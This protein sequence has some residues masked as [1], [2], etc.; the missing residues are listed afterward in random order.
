MRARLIPAALSGAL[1]A[2]GPLAGV[3]D[4]TVSGFF[5]QRLELDSNPDLESSDFSSGSANSIT[6]LGVVLSMRTPRTT[7]TFAPGINASLRTDQSVT[8]SN[9]N[10]RV[11][12]RVTRQGERL[13][14]SGGMSVVPRLTNDGASASD[15]SFSAAPGSPDFTDA[16]ALEVTA[17]ADARARYK[18]D[19]RNSV[20]TGA[21]AQARRFSKDSGQFTD[22][23]SYGVDL[24]WTRE[25]DPRTSLSLKTAFRAFSED[26]GGSDEQSLDFTAGG[27]RRLSPTLSA[28]GDIGVSF[29]DSG[30]STNAGLIG[31]ARLNYQ[32]KDTSLV[33]GFRQSVDQNEFGDLENRSSAFITPSYRATH[34]ASV[35]L[36][37][38]MS[39]TNPMFS[40]SGGSDEF[41]VSVG[42][43]LSYDLTPEWRID[44]GYRLR[45]RAESGRTDTS[46]LV[47]LQLSRNLTL[48]P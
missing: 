43:A 20:S 26:G 10:P 11:S 25:I 2:V 47:F 31:G 36:P 37:V 34:Q 12:A 40:G 32:G 38:Q 35:S 24:G 17:R 23:D 39:F 6:D 30:G 42:P 15:S 22:S 18:V 21:F 7:L 27:D 13:E 41:S 48:L 1:L 16:T 8:F 9:V 33:F 14:L 44:T 5:S 45:A 19:L 46:S 3:A 29:S 28:G 4:V